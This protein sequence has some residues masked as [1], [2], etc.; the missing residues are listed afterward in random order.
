M[1][2]KDFAYHTL[3][4]APLHWHGWTMAVPGRCQGELRF[5]ACHLPASCCMPAIPTTRLSG[6]GFFSY[7]YCTCMYRFCGLGFWAGKRDD[8]AFWSP[9]VYCHAFS[10]S[11]LFYH[12]ALPF[13]SP[14]YLRQT[15]MVGFAETGL[16]LRGR[17]PPC[18]PLYYLCGMPPTD[19]MSARLLP[20]AASALR[21][22]NASADNAYQH[23]VLPLLQHTTICYFYVLYLDLVLV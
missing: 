17:L 11:C 4:Y 5:V 15:C 6:P 13:S 3:A 9:A 1:E 20:T 12:L 7:Y 8:N 22:R 16:R 10:G 21:L 18:V 2:K 23:M 19:G 14:A